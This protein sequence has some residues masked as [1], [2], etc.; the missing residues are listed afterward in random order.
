MPLRFRVVD[1][2]RPM[3]TT[4]VIRV[5]LSSETHPWYGM[6]TIPESLR[7]PVRQHTPAKRPFESVTPPPKIA[8]EAGW[9]TAKDAREEYGLNAHDLRKVTGDYVRNGGRG[10]PK[11]LYNA[12]R[13][14]E[15][16]AL[17]GDARSA[18]RML[19]LCP[20][21][22]ASSFNPPSSPPPPP[23][24]SLPPSDL[25]LPNAVEYSP[26]VEELLASLPLLGC[27]HSD[28][29]DPPSHGLI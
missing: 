26:G 1:R 2:V 20:E 23:I 14:Q 22:P 15:L 7:T 18:K 8:T 21:A 29:V 28:S 25:F 24:P 6:A 5:E 27:Q 16:A 12:K 3:E 13:L 17:K 10:G 4:S 11:T 9:K 19:I